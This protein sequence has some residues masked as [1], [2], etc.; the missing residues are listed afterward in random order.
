MRHAVVL[1]FA[2]LPCLLAGTGCLNSCEQVCAEE[3]RYIDG[4]LEEWDA[5]WPDFGYDGLADVDVAEKG[6]AAG[7]AYERGPAEEYDSRC[8]ERYEAAIFFSHP[9]DA[10][11]IRTECTTRIRSVALA[12][13][14]NDYSP[15]GTSGLDP[16]G[17]EGNGVPPRPGR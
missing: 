11:T 12:V 10:R 3:A 5:L 17:D 2:L 14:C 4:C 16:N 8:K 7:D 15:S 13:S 9:E 1:L 6:L